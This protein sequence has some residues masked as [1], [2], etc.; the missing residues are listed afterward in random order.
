[1]GKIKVEHMVNT[2]SNQHLKCKTIYT[3]TNCHARMK[4][5]LKF[6]FPINMTANKNFLSVVIQP[7]L[8]PASEKQIH[9]IDIKSTFQNI[10]Q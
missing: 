10:Y 8:A 3:H 6:H 1:M 9:F 4:R 2:T 5:Y 7:L